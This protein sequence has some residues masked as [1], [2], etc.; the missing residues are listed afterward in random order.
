MTEDKQKLDKIC[1]YYNNSR[2]EM[3]KYIPH[4]VKTTLEFGCGCGNFSQLIKN[5]FNVECWGVEIDRQAAEK[6]SEKLYKIINADAHQALNQ[7]PENY[8]DCIIFNDVLEHL[9]D[10]YS[11]LRDIKSKLKSSGVIVASIP[12]VRFWS[13]IFKLT[14]HGQW[15]YRDSGI[16]DKTHLRF[17]TYKSLVKMFNELNYDLLAIE[18]LHPTKSFAFKII[19]ALCFNRL[20]DAEFHQFACVAR[21]V[22]NVAVK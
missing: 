4:D 14:V 9:Q 20:K 12:N 15:D 5:K 21:P 6:A 22:P 19:N 16:L 10:P 8:F 1:D 3:L 2:D 18:G 11:L 13:I 7:I 17:F